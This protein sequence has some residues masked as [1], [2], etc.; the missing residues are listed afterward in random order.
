MSVTRN[1]GAVIVEEKRA[2]VVRV[3]SS[4]NVDDI[5]GARPRSLPA[6]ARGTSFFT[7]QDIEGAQPKTLHRP[8]SYTPEFVEGAFPTTL[9]CSAPDAPPFPVPHYLLDAQCCLACCCLCRTRET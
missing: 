3:P 2:R 9:A 8:V 6:R 1:P 7:T 4:L 5:A